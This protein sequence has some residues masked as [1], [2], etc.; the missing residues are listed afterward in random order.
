M[1]GGDTVPGFPGT[2]DFD[3]EAGTLFGSGGFR[4]GL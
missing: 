2:G 1:S 3:A 4:I